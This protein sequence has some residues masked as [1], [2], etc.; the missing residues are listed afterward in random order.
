MKPQV[1]QDETP[2]GRDVVIVGTIGKSPLINR[3]VS[4]GKLDVE[5][6][7]GKW[8]TTLEQV[9]E[10]PMPGVRRAFVIA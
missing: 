1:T 2:S 7:A 3:L 9:V 8:E 10:H 5:G 6:I 4:S